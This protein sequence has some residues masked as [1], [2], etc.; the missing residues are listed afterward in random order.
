NV[1]LNVGPISGAS[2]RHLHWHVV[3]RYFGDLN[4]LEIL[5]T[6]VLVETLP[7]TLEKLLKERDILLN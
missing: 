4:F 6:R 1:G 5:N 3:P 2:I 7:Q